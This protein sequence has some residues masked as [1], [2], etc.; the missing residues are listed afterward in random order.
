MQ[1]QDIYLK[2]LEINDGDFLYTIFQH[3]EYAEMFYEESTTLENSLY[4]K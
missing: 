4:E 2:E 1:K 3:K